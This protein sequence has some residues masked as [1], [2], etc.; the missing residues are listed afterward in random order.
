MP[1]K[2]ITPKAVIEGPPR[3]QCPILL[4]QTSFKALDEP[5]AFT[6]AHG[7]H[8]ARFGEIE[9]RGV[10]LTPKGRALYDQLLNAARDELGAHSP[11][12]PTPSA[13]PQLMAQHFH[14]FP[15]NHP[16][17]ARAGL[18][19]LSLL[20]VTDKGLTA[21]A[22]ADQAAPQSL[23][24]LV[25]CR[26]RGDIEPLVYEDFSAGQRGGDLPVEP[27]RCGAESLRGQRQ[28]SCLRTGP[29]PPAPLMS[30]SCMQH[31]QQRSIDAC[32]Q[33]LRT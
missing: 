10:A 3:R 28:P 21:R 2:G 13:I 22:Q 5:I 26:S 6:D 16:A 17:D 8:S 14:A 25:E 33:V 24:A 31:T 15:D 18:G 30:C 19:V 11:M 4:R 20:R 32:L 9:Q 27:G 12:K 1:G 23:D 7:S 29:G